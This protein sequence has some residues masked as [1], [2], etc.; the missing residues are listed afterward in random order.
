MKFK[1]SKIL[2]RKNILNNTFTNRNTLN[3]YTQTLDTNE[4][5]MKI[6]TDNK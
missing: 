5:L 1:M 3:F 2:I 6:T 4:H